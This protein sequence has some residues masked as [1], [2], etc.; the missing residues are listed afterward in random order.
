M[1]N[2]IVAGTLYRIR[3]KAR[4][5]FS[6]RPPPMDEWLSTPEGQQALAEFERIAAEDHQRRYPAPPDES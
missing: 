5:L 1:F 6:R 4:H 3:L 2:D